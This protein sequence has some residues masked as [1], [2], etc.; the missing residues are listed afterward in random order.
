MKYTFITLIIALISI[1]SCKDRA[2]LAKI[3]NEESLGQSSEHLIDDSKKLVELSDL[4]LTGIGISGLLD[5]YTNISNEFNSTVS[6][7]RDRNKALY[8]EL[9]ETAGNLEISIL[10]KPSEKM[11]PE[12]EEFKGATDESEI[13]DS[14]KKWI[15]KYSSQ[16]EDIATWMI[17]SSDNK[18]IIDLGT[19]VNS[20]S[21]ALKRELEN[22][23]DI[24]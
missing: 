12:I 16:I 10:E 15:E 9:K 14:Y 24:S 7:L 1:Y 20:Y 11:V 21:Y 17:Q 3:E 22:L 19:K 6:F 5:K 23:N 4:V 18:E 13:V 8:S 2:N